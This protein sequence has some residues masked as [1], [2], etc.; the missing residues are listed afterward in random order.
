MDFEGVI[1]MKDKLWRI[2]D[3][4]FNRVSEGLRVI[5]D[6]ARFYLEASAITEDLKKVRLQ[7]GNLVKPFRPMILAYRDSESDPGKEVS[8]QL[9]QD[10]RKN[11]RELIT[12]NFKRAEEGLRSLEEYLKLLDRYEIAKECER[13]RF[14]TYTLEKNV[15][16]LLYRAARPQLPATDLYCLT[17]LEYSRGRNNL[18]VV[19]EMLEAGIKIVQYREKDLTM[20]QKYQECDEI[21]KITAE[22][23][24]TFII[25]DDIHLALA[26]GADGIH[27]GQDDL[28]V[29]KAQEM[30][31]GRMLVGLSTHS[32]EQA[33]AAVAAGIDYIG[34]GPIYRTYTKK[35]A[36]A[37]V[38]LD[39]VRFAAGNITIPW[40]AIGGIKEDNVMEVIQNGARMVAMVTEIVGAEDIVEKIAAIRRGIGQAKESR[41]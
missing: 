20:K 7:L 39:Y 34:V 41:R 25:N 10:G 26:I 11:L 35:N 4:E 5:E 14:D 19:R 36:C 31:G 33:I 24:A 22:A 38:G 8:F 18:E 29:P 28:P 37:P 27:L 21:R 9:Q 30:V 2:V 16:K 13:L 15:F 17:S 40:V 3:A 6:L 23:G 1:L 12:A 32:P